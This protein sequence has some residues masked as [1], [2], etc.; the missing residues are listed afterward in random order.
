MGL[1]YTYI[2]SAKPRAKMS[3]K[4][5]READLKT[6]LREDLVLTALGRYQ[7]TPAVELASGYV[8]ML[9]CR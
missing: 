9:L 3:A 2:D 8:T 1:L 7:D 5:D 4:H 6:K